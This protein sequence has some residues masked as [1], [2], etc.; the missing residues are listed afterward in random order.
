MKTQISLFIT[1]LF[2]TIFSFGQEKQKEVFGKLFAQED[3]KLDLN[4]I[5]I[6]LLEYGLEG[7]SEEIRAKVE[8]VK[9]M[10]GQDDEAHEFLIKFLMILNYLILICVICKLTKH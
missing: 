3:A 4:T 8:D 10:E 5:E 1:V 6:A 9:T 7:T 2:I